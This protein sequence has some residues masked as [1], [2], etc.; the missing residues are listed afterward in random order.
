M[1]AEETPRIYTGSSNVETANDDRSN[2]S[3]G[4][5]L[6]S[7]ALIGA[8]VLIEPELLGGA[9]LG[10]GVVYGLPL[11]SQLLRPVIST[12]VQLG[13]AAVDSVGDLL[14]GARDE[15]QRVISNARS[16]Y[17]RSRSESIITKDT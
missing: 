13:Y 6:T 8:G 1:P 5:L 2:L 4:R 15:V 7:A 14:A 11:V 3:S 17:Q 16:D 9:L 10:A 12:T